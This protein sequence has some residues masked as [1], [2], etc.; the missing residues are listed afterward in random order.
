MA[1][2][3]HVAEP[4]CAEVRVTQNRYDGLIHGTLRLSAAMPRSQE[5][6]TI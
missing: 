6:T 4:V 1:D 3:A 2:E 5:P